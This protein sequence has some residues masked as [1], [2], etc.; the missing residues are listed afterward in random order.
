MNSILS[1]SQ[2]IKIALIIFLMAISIPLVIFDGTIDH[3]VPKHI[4]EIQEISDSG[5]LNEENTN[6]IQISGFY[7]LGATIT[8]LTGLAAEVL[9]Y[10]PFQLLPHI[11]LFYLILYKLSGNSLISI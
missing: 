5:R 8:L 1:R 6:V 3:F 10:L 11:I 9:I 2:Q 4:A 7:I